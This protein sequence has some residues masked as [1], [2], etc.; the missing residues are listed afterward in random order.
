[1]VLKYSCEQHHP[2]SRLINLTNKL[3]HSFGSHPPCRGRTFPSWP[4]RLMLQPR[5][6][7]L[8]Q[9]LLQI[10]IH[11]L[12]A[13]AALPDS[14]AWQC[15]L[16][17]MYHG[18]FVNQPCYLPAPVLC[19]PLPGVHLGG[20]LALAP[21]LVGLAVQLWKLCLLPLLLHGL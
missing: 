2:A 4:G 3:P 10:D 5:H 20:A 1:M 19:I 21:Q 14:S 16:A 11:L 6:P 18:H 7:Q 15:G 12:Y 9:H 13:S 8:E 17:N